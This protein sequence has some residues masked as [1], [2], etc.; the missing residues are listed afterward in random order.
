MIEFHGEIDLSLKGIKGM[1]H[2]TRQVLMRKRK[3]RSNISCLAAFKGVQ[4]T[5]MC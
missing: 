1:N 5:L 2:R 4:K 3:P